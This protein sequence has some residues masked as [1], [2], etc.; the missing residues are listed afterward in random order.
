MSAMAKS[1]RL[2]RYFSLLSLGI[3][4]L[5]GVGLGWM[6]RQLA[7]NQVVAEAHDSNVEMAR[8]FRTTAFEP[9]SA[10][11]R[12]PS[13]TPP[14]RLATSAEYRQLEKQVA[15]LLKDSNFL[16]LTA[17]DGTGAVR[18]STDPSQLSVRPIPPAG[19]ASAL[20]GNEPPRMDLRERFLGADGSRSDIF[21]VR[22]LVP[23]HLDGGGLLEIHQDVTVF[24]A[25]VMG[26][27]AEY[28]VW[29]AVGL[30]LLYLL[31][32][33]VVRHLDALVLGKDRELISANAALERRIEERTHDL[34]QRSVELETALA[35]LSRNRLRSMAGQEALARVLRADDFQHGN[36]ET[37]LD[38]LCGEFATA[39]D[40]ARVGVW[41]MADDGESMVCDQYY[42]R[43]R[44]GANELR[45]V[46]ADVPAYFDGLHA[47]EVLAA[48][49][50]V[51]HAAV[52]SLG[53]TYLRAE[54]ILS[55]LDVP[56]NVRGRLWGLV[57]FEE[58][59]LR[60]HWSHQD[61][62][63]ATAGAALVTLAIERIDRQDVERRLSDLSAR[64]QVTLDT[65]PAGI[66]MVGADLR[67]VFH[68]RNANLISGL[69]AESDWVG[70]SLRDFLLVLARNGAY[71][72]GD[73]GALVDTRLEY[74]L[75]AARDNAVTSDVS[76]MNGTRILRVTR[77]PLTPGGFVVVAFDV[78]AERRAVE[79]LRHAKE[80]AESANAAK[81]EFLSSMSHELRTPMNAILG[82]AQLMELDDDLPAD[83]RDSLGEIIRA[84]EH[85]LGLI[86]QVL[87]LA[88]IEAG[89][90][91]LS[92]ES[93]ALDSVITESLSL[94]NSLALRRSV[95][96]QR[97][98]MS[99]AIVHAD[100]TRLK[101]A[102]LNLLSNAIKYNR[103]GG[104][105][106]VDVSVTGGGDWRISVVDTGR[107]IPRDRLAELFQPFNRLSAAGGEI[108]GTGIG[109]NLTRRMVELMG[110]GIGVESTEGVGSRFWIDLPRQPEVA[111]SID[112]PD[113]TGLEPVRTVLYVEDNPANIR[114]VSQ[115]LARRGEIDLL[116]AH[117][118]E[119]GLELART[120]CPDLILL[121][122][123]L[124]GMNGY[125]V[126]AEL[127]AGPLTEATPVVALTANA[128]PRDI[129]FGMAAG[130]DAYLTK[131]L[132]VAHFNEVIDRCLFAKETA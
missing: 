104:R 53:A 132:D 6:M 131:P 125:D 108:E 32:V 113:A 101:Q 39:L 20:A 98:G 122:I 88:R 80:A 74:F 102:L 45:L 111:P 9:Y 54:G 16:R 69:P 27:L 90:V 105:V 103:E 8:L 120:R 40:V 107:G 73:P 30:F 65:A 1:G 119:L 42:G 124:P 89:H 57:S 55:K 21:V 97:D 52:G 7:L 66:Y 77:S 87:D 43:S 128:A 5:V 100:R 38:Y 19:L 47:G 44:T 28:T 33:M 48:E 37:A 70:H 110:G 71:G 23:L 51:G 84:G 75:S 22:S 118:P 96:V 12:P 99:G 35:D 76:L 86:N 2:T 117:T 11:D 91:D 41:R 59:V 14:Q 79:D 3:I 121:D 82:F 68:N 114:L 85:L 115:I 72:P 109:L 81:S 56:I 29:L 4:V 36:L 127:K 24:R 31:Q 112:E 34:A 15:S 61:I 78:T 67:V 94:V 25:R 50:A 64:L 130:F 83:H 10:L 106:S 13:A 17:I 62:A 60:R 46:R 92:L 126:L 18:F 129:E 95:T 63:F 93:V 26:A 116:S 123:N 58:S 49:D